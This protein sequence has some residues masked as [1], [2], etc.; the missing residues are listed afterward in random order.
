VL[1]E[2]WFYIFLSLVGAIFE[3]VEMVMQ[4][5]YTMAFPAFGVVWMPW[6]PGRRWK[7]EQH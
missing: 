5:L 6:W 4:I 2:A 1:I 7:I 3:Q